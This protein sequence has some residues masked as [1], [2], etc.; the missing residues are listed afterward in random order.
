MIISRTRK[1][2]IDTRTKLAIFIDK[3]KDDDRA[4]YEIIDDQYHNEILEYAN[5]L[6]EVSFPELKYD[7][8]PGVY[9]YNKSLVW[10]DSSDYCDINFNLT[11][12]Q[13]HNDITIELVN[14]IVIID[15]DLRVNVAT[16]DIDG[17]SKIDW[18]DQSTIESLPQ[19]N[20]NLYNSLLINKHNQ[21][22]VTDG[23]ANVFYNEVLESLSEMYIFNEPIYW[24][25]NKPIQYVGDSGYPLI[26]YNTGLLPSVRVKTYNSLIIMDMNSLL[27]K[28]IDYAFL[29]MNIVNGIPTPTTGVLVNSPLYEWK[30]TNSIVTGFG[31][32][33]ALN[34]FYD[35]FRAT[36]IGNN[37]YLDIDYT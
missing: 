30:F 9:A 8:D 33:D 29:D 27:L 32:E 36:E 35:L 7:I 11:L 5:S 3:Y 17:L 34:G 12:N 15:T 37:A 1:E 13:E 23:Y 16:P 21:S 19:V 4:Y 28:S 24:M 26:I 20:I 25:D 6:K 18:N 10:I 22:V 2:Y 31:Q 14:S